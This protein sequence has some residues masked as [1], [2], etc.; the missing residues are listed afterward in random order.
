M[1]LLCCITLQI[2]CVAREQLCGHITGKFNSFPPKDKHV[3][4]MLFIQNKSVK[5]YKNTLDTC[6]TTSNILQI[7]EICMDGTVQ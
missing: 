4:R 2:A 5:V 3:G 1:Y 6:G 7:R